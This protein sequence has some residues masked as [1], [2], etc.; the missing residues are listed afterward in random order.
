[1]VAMAIATRKQ[2]SA[3]EGDLKALRDIQR[4]FSSGRICATLSDLVEGTMATMPEMA[5]RILLRVPASVLLVGLLGQ[6]NCAGQSDDGAP[7]CKSLCDQGMKECPDAPRVD[8]E[9]QCLYE[10]ARAEETGCRKHVRAVEKCSAAL[11][12]ICTAATACSSELREFWQCVGVYCEK[13]RG[14]QYCAMP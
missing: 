12:N 1:M 7:S 9:G 13:H 10:D 8:C 4:Q 5:R 2:S 11:D 14:S 6:M 3:S